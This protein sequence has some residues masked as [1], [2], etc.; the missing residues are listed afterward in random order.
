MNDDVGEESAEVIRMDG[1]RDVPAQRLKIRVRGESLSRLL[2][3][4][5]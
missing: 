1:N 4:I 5:E 3:R 2:Y